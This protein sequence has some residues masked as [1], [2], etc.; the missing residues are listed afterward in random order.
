MTPYGVQTH[1][2]GISIEKKILGIFSIKKKSNYQKKVAFK[3]FHF[4]FKREKKN[5]YNLQ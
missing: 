5:I 4:I 1:E 2:I 3:F